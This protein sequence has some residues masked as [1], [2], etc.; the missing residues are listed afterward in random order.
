[1][2]VGLDIT[3][4]AAAPV[5]VALAQKRLA[6]LGWSE[7]LLNHDLVDPLRI[8]RVGFA[9]IAGLLACWVAT[10]SDKPGVV[11]MGCLSRGC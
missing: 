4:V 10:P 2:K 11:G 8:D 6:D 7:R 5:Q 3:A 9:G 1:M